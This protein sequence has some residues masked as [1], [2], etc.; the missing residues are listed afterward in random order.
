MA[1]N[2]FSDQ[3]VIP[4]Q[5]SISDAVAP[6][7]RPVH[8]KKVSDYPGVSLGHRYVAQNYANPLLLGP[9]IC[10]E[11]IAL[12]QHMFTEEEAALV[13]HIRL[14]SG[15]T[16]ATVAS[17]AHRP[18]G[19][20]RPI[21]DRLAAQGLLLTFGSGEK[22]RYSLL[23][24]VPGTFEVVLL[25]PSLD[26]LTDWHRRFAELFSALYATGFLAEYTEHPLSAARVLPVSQSVE[27]HPMALPSDQLE[28]V[29]D[30]YDTFAVGLCQCRM[31]EQIVGNGC[32]RP[33]ETCVSFGD[34][35]KLLLRDDRMREVEKRDVLT[36]KAEAE[37][38][39]LAT[40]VSD[41]AL[42]KVAGGA[43][44][45]CCGCCCHAFRT[46]SQ[47]NAPGLIAP[48]R[49]VPV[50]DLTQCV[51]C[52]RCAQACPMGAVSVDTSEKT[53]RWSHERCVGCGLCSVA[54]DRAG[55]LRMEPHPNREPP[56]E[57]VISRLLQI[58]PN[59]LRNVWSVWRKYR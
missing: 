9:P 52:G 14:P 45:S 43:S 34:L 53:F 22:M 3:R 10:D 30:R 28:I 41:A 51:Y 39:G 4:V 2:E 33:L 54:C 11:L 55:A 5:T 21:L 48:A 40:W 7:L 44:C 17:A 23:P 35:A 50:V 26:T 57:S 13:Q 32:D 6:H 49:F 37:S 56:P 47:F 59:Y 1:E 27:A 15:K 36:I 19:E 20:V 25:R 24:L 31:T 12:V 16:A 18:V 46:V 58:V 38:A 29:L 8:V 42:G